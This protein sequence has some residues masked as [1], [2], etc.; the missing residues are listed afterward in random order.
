MSATPGAKTP[1]RPLSNATAKHDYEPGDTTSRMHTD[2]NC[3]ICGAP[4][5]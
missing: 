4:K 5:H 1:R 2:P 3:R